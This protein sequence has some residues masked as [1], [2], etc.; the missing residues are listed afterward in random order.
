[1][2]KY[3]LLLFLINS[4]FSYTEKSLEKPL[5]K[6]SK[7]EFKKIIHTVLQDKAFGTVVTNKSRKWDFNSKE[8]EKEPPKINLEV[9]AKVL[10]IIFIGFGILVIIYLL[11]QIIRANRGFRR[12]LAKNKHRLEVAGLEIDQEEVEKKITQDLMKLFNQRYFREVISLLFQ[13]T[14]IQLNEK[15]NINWLKHY[16]ERDCLKVAKQ[17]LK[18]PSHRQILSFFS[19]IVDTRIQI[20]YGGKILSNEKILNLIQQHTEIQR[21]NPK[22]PII[23]AHQDNNMEVNT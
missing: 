11:Y 3:L 13:W 20:A 16:T 6:L 12:K 9:I 22:T 18:N 10:R 15:E 5:D 7:K 19:D 1:L 4:S 17:T 2:N 21:N 8:E 14:L 23:A